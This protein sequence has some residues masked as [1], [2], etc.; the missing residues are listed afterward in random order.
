MSGD[1]A[2]D[3]VAQTAGLHRLGGYTDTDV[4]IDVFD[5]ASAASVAER[6]AVPGA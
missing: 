1:A 3:V 4:V 2:N 5:T 6:T